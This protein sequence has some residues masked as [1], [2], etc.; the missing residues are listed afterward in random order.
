MQT[1]NS[2]AF[3]TRLPKREAETMDEAIA[4]EELTVS[5]FLRRAVRYYAKKNPDKILALAEEGSVE[6]FVMELGR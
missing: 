2:K 6:Q 4:E 1:Q 3:A 5:Q